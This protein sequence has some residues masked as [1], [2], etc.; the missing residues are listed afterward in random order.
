VGVRPQRAKFPSVAANVAV[1]IWGPY[2]DLAV[3]G[4]W[5][6]DRHLPATLQ[7]YIGKPPE[8]P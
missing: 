3:S 8:Y 2:T 4:V 5:E 7:I 6:D 1:A